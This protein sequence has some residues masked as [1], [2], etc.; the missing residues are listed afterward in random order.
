MPFQ[1]TVNALPALGVPGDFASNNPRATVI[2]GPGALV[3]GASV[4]VSNPSGLVVGRFA[5]LDPATY[6]V[7][8]NNAPPGAAGQPNGFVKNDHTALITQY[9]GETSMTIPAGFG[10]TLFDAG[11]FLV[12]NDGTT[13]ATPGMKA[14]ANFADGKCT[15]AAAGAPAQGASVTASVAASTASVTGSI[16]GDVLTVTA[17]GSGTLVAGGILSGTGVAAGT[18]IESQLT[19]TPGGIGTYLVSIPEQT[20]ASTTIS[21]TYGTMTVSAVGSGA[22]AIGNVLAGTGVTAGTYITAFGTGTGGTGT[23]IV[24]PNTVV[25]STT[26]TAVNNVETGWFCRSFAAAGEIAVISSRAMG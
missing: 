15:F 8:T 7:A 18:A 13:E 14:Y 23:Y 6:T 19:G 9:L 24:T 2:A 4:G 3:A 12:K 10:V 1:T 17:V 20:V 11:D 25:S 21:E 5:W 22:L 16:S 26:V